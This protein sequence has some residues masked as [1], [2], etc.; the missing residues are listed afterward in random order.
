VK[1]IVLFVLFLASPAWAQQPIIAEDSEDETIIEE[2]VIQKNYT[3]MRFRGINKIT[4]RSQQIEASMGTV[5]RFGNLEVIPRGCWV[6]PANKRPEEAGLMEVWYWKEGEKP[7]LV[8]FGWMFASSPALSS[9]E[10]PVYDI[11]MLECIAEKVEETQEEKDPPPEEA[12]AQE[13]DNM[14]EIDEGVTIL[15]N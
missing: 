15:S 7:T 6:A 8:F 1:F 3:G 11:T 14:P 13:P 10:H 4:T 5:T 9:L 2:P 12:S